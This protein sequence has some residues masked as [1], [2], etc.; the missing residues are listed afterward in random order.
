MS[1]ELSI[2]IPLYNSEKYLSKCLDSVCPQINNNVEIILINDCS[3][4]KSV[5]I[6]KRYAKKF[7]FIKIIN[8]KKNNGVSYSRNNGIN[9]ATGKYLCFLDSDDL[10]LKKSINTIL[11][12]IKIFSGMDLFVLR[13]HD[14][15]KKNI[16]KNQ[17]FNIKKIGNKSIINNITNFKKFRATCWNF[18]V[19]K[20][21]LYL[22]NI[23][24]NNNI[25]IF[26]DQVFVSKILC[27]AEDFKIIERPVYIR[28]IFEPDTL[29]KKV[30]Y[31]IVLS[32]INIIYQ[33]SHFIYKKNKFLN[34]KKIK[35]LYSRLKFVTEQLLLNITI[36]EPVEIKNASKNIKNDLPLI[37]KVLTFKNKNFNFLGKKKIN[38][39]NYLLNYKLKKV[40]FLE[41]VLNKFNDKKIILFCTGS[42]TKIILKTFIKLGANINII[43]DNNIYFSGKKLETATIRNLSYLKKKG[44]KVFNPK[45]LICN[46]NIPEV[47]KIKLQLNRIGI[48][49]KNLF[50]VKI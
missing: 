36:C 21:F 37:Q 46:K 5:Q 49:N 31:N 50:Q 15:S 30:G 35:F 11:K 16:D 44:K 45:I 39:N 27:L 41:N 8:Q 2:I 32:C 47:K 13:S 20:K 23:K 19:K 24:F 6:C 14:I 12:K 38:I 40:K 18:I 28:R 43:I 9:Q 48:E 29:G 3:T 22:N 4:D 34:K 17:I 25:K 7:N 10:L 42:Y 1:T 33:I 26:E